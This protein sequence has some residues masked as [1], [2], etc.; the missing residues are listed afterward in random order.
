M[1][2]IRSPFRLSVAGGATDLP[3]YYSK[4]KGQLITAA[5]NKYMYVIINDKS[6]DDKIRLYYKFTEIKDI[7][8][9]NKIDHNIIRESLKLH[10][11][12]HPIEIG[13][14][15]QIPAGSGMGSSS[16]FTVALLAGLNTLKRN[17]ISPLQLAEEACKVEIDLVGKPIGKQDQYATTF[18]GINKLHIDKTGEVTVIPFNLDSETIFELENRLLMFYT[19]QTRDANEILSEQS[20]KISENESTEY[21]HKI[22]QIGIA[23]ERALRNGDINDFGSLLDDHWTMKKYIT[24]SMTNSKID[25]LYELGLMNG[26]IGGK[27]CGAGG[28]G[29]LLFCVKEGK[30]KALITAMQNRGLKYM[31]FRFEFEG[32]KVLT[33]I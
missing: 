10:N 4:Y 16:V 32:C 19:G 9:I 26:A 33:N 5:I 6:I 29:F 11:I 24:G 14:F 21:M 28:G 1:I 22:K 18:G 3:A 20:R 30:R 25:E 23:I 17:F 8:E 15:S 7:A 27:V 2:I 31:D 12:N 13:S